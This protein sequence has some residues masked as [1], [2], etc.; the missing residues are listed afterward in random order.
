VPVPDVCVEWLQLW[1]ER[2]EE[3]KQRTSSTADYLFHDC[4]LG[5]F[6]HLDKPQST[7]ALRY[8]VERAVAEALG[9]DATERVT[10]HTFRH[11]YVTDRLEDGAPI[12]AVAALAG[13]ASVQ[14]T[15]I[16]TH[17]RPEYLS[18]LVRDAGKKKRGTPPQEEAGG[19][20]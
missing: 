14:T 16:Y 20:A 5:E 6:H 2:S 3:W 4:L 10:C 13:H 18:D 15:Q 11:T 19:R 1:R 8:M 17:L 9:D 7:R 12:E